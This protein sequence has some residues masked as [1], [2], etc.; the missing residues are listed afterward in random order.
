MNKYLFIIN[1]ITRGGN[2]T[3]R[4]VEFVE[5]HSGLDITLYTTQCAG[6]AEEK[7]S[8]SA[9]EGYSH[10]ISVGGD[11][12]L[13]EIL[14]G[15]MK[16]DR[17]QRPVLGTI[18]AG[19]GNDFGRMIGIPREPAIAFDMI[20]RNHVT[21][22]DVCRVNDHYFINN[23]GAGFD[24]KASW[25]AE[26]ARPLQ[27]MLR[28]LA[29]IFLAFM[30]YKG[31]EM[32]VVADGE[33]FSEKYLLAAVGNGSTTGGG[34]PMTPNADL[35]DGLLDVCLVR[36][37]PIFK[38]LIL[39]PKV[40]TGKHIEH[41]VVREFRCRQLHLFALDGIPIYYDGELPLP[42]KWNDMLIEVVRD[43][44]RIITGETP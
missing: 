37:I 12:T 41:P 6:D 33:R 14:N 44:I 39:L 27:G 4:Y 20:L 31:Y 15:L 32:D 18:P 19:G 24:A 17:N 29:G 8:M 23:L 43:R 36:H 35:R 1:P 22:V 21:E 9:N 42:E 7:A 13:N 26:K 16:I 10:V 25:L 28:Y 34:I 30:S 11:G 3:H 40:F 5:D 38:A 2:K